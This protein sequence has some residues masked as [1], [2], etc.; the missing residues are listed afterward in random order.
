MKNK[1]V[2]SPAIGC[3]DPSKCR[4]ATI[5]DKDENLQTG[6]CTGGGTGC[7]PAAIHEAEHSVIH[8][9][10]LIDATK[11]IKKIL[12]AIPPH[13][14]GHKLSFIVTSQGVLL[15]WLDHGLVIPPDAKVII[16]GEADEADFV[17]AVKIKD[18]KH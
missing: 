16:Q 13:A 7:I 10:S 17:K 3:V 2:N 4:T 1:K 15:A 6:G 11:K 14:H 12:A 9:Q 8:H 5:L 18:W